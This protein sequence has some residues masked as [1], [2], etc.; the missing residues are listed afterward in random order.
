MRQRPQHILSCVP[1][2][3]DGGFSGEASAQTV[4]RL[5]RYH[6]LSKDYKIQLASRI[7]MIP[8]VM[9]NM[10]FHR[11]K[12]G[13]VNFLHTLLG[14]V[15]GRARVTLQSSRTTATLTPMPTYE[16][17]DWYQTPLYYD[18]VFDEGTAQEAD[19]LEAVAARHATPRPAVGCSAAVGPSVSTQ[20]TPRHVLEPACGS[21]RLMAELA[22]RGHRVA[23]VDLSEGMLAFARKRFKERKVPARAVKLA[24]GPMQ[25]FDLHQFAQ[26]AGGTG[27]QGRGGYDLAHILV[28]SFKYLLTEE[29]AADCLRCICDHLRPGGVLVLGLHL[30]EY[31]DPDSTLERWR[32]QRGDTDVICTIKGWPP[33]ARTRCEQVRSRIVVREPGL[34]EPG[35]YES[36]WDFRTYDAQQL[37]AL[38]RTEPRFKHLATYTFHHDIARRTTLDGDDLGVVLVLR[39]DG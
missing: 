26:P 28:S 12:P 24:Q 4:K 23:G 32:V 29:D 16:P 5:G 17:F 3:V 7:A 22:L 19:F 37:R 30:S 39:R 35:R 11:L 8:R 2:H 31:D 14:A 38:L 10:M 6:R 34:A 13:S 18:I 21:G 33:D 25:A 9:I 15:R 1:T 36:R 20:G 27:R